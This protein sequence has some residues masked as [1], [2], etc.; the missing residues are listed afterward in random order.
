MSVLRRAYVAVDPDVSQFDE[1]LKEKFAKQDPGGKAGKQ[2]G[3]Q[4]NRALK[5]LDLDPVDIKA[6]PKQAFAALDATEAKL[7]ALAANASTIEIKVAAERGL[8]QIDSFRKQVGSLGDAGGEGATSFVG[9]FAAKAGVLLRAAPLAPAIAAGVAT[10]GPTIGALVAG[11]VVG[12]AGIGGVVGGVV[13][14]SRDPRVKEAGKQLGAQLLTD[15]TRRADGFVDPLIAGIGQIREGWAEAGDDLDRIFRSSRFIDP[16]VEG[17]ISG[18]QAFIAGFADAVE[19]ADPAI[20]ALS[21]LLTETGA[22]F[23]EMFTE[24]S[25]HADEGASGI[26]D[27]TDVLTTL[28]DVG[29]AVGGMFAEVRGSFG[30]VSREF[31]SLKWAYEDWANEENSLYKGLDL[32]ADGFD[33]GTAEAQSY[34]DMILGAGD[35]ADVFTL[36]AAGMTD[37]QIRDIDATNKA[38]A[39]ANAQTKAEEE[40][41]WAIAATTGQIDNMVVTEGRLKDLQDNLTT[42]QDDYKRSLD[43]LAPKLTAARNLADGL[44][45][46]QQ[47][48]FSAAINGVE[49]NESYQSSWDSL[50]ESVKKNRGSL[51]VHTAAGRANR[52]SLQGLLQSSNELYFANIEAGQSTESARKKHEA[53]TAAIRDE[54]RELGLDRTETQK[55]ISTYG[56]IPPTKTTEIIQTGLDRIADQLEEIYYAQRALAEGKTVAQIKAQIQNAKQG[57]VFGGFAAGG[58]TGNVGVREEAGVV[59]GREFV[60]RADS[61]AKVRSRYPGL[62]E[63]MNATGQLPGYASGGFVAPVET[64]SKIPMRVNL[65]NTFVMPLKAALAK[66]APAFD[67]NWPSSPSAQRG[68]SGVWRRVLQ[69]IRS[70]PDQGSFGNAYRP[71]DPKWHGSG[72]AV[73]W[74]GFN[75]DSL[76]SFLAAK[77]PLELIHRTKTRDYAYTRGVNKGSFNNPLMEAHRNHIH[78]AMDDGGARVLQPGLNIIPNNTGRPE[79]IAGPAAVST[80]AGSTGE[81]F[82]RLTAEIERQNTLLA[83]ILAATGAVGADVAGALGA[84]TRRAMQ[85]ARSATSPTG[86]TA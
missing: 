1:R 21:D 85:V 24:L 86:V 26:R 2:L 76:A 81:H 18:G 41:K 74:M 23:G 47:S 30:A 37:A 17:A 55:L 67:S 69:L 4:L 8:K 61:T 42:S 43:E 27:L 71:G 38:V 78:I 52:D 39:A 29:S 63:E 46:A 64:R 70:G 50:S 40:R 57:P 56:K 75:M 82:D 20:D 15:L 14:A 44:R 72:R 49:A 22:A 34:R 62:L 83:Q 36:R 33:R 77:R 84:G 6:D 79:P 66:V 11:A 12:G 16:L 19:S 7:K 31:N 48:L 59:H 53:R 32:T 73:D 28:I 10:V 68:D 65:G 45:Q 9:T 3:G 54:A 25:D 60:I 35:A 5:R 58:Y 13:L 80:L 51:D